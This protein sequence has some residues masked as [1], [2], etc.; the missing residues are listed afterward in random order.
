MSTLEYLDST[1]INSEIV[2][3]WI[4]SSA[5][6]QIVQGLGNEVVLAPLLYPPLM[7]RGLL[8]IGLN[9]SFVLKTLA[10]DHNLPEDR[11]NNF[12]NIENINNQEEWIKQVKKATTNYS[13]F[14]K[15]NTLTIYLNKYFTTSDFYWEHADLLFI[16][17]TQQSEL[18]EK[19]GLKKTDN[20]AN[21]ENPIIRKF[22]LDQL[23]LIKRIIESL[24][25]RILLIVNAKTSRIFKEYFKPSWSDEHGCYLT[26]INKKQI[27][28]HLTGML[29]GQRALDNE[30]FKTL[31]WNVKYSYNSLHK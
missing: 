14:K 5:P 11:I 10:K 19:I 2:D 23:S 9:P 8:F 21:I 29:T 28:T 20:P 17:K 1:S 7:K 31:K 25:P 3:I 6:R 12:Y 16:R 4:K 30:S 22:I 15:F 13:Y 27:Q 26:E 18:L 24:K